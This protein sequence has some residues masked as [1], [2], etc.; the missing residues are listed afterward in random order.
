MGRW[1]VVLVLALALGAAFVYWEREPGPC[2]C[3][4]P[5]GPSERALAPPPVP[6]SDSDLLRQH[7]LASLAVFPGPGFPA[8]LPWGTLQQIGV[9]DGV[10]L[11]NL[12]HNH[13]LTFLEMCL[14]RYENEVHGYN[15]VMLKRERIGGKLYPP[16]G[17]EKVRASFREKPFSVLMVWLE[18]GRQAQKV[19]YVEGENNDKMLVRPAG[20][21]LSA[22][23]VTRDVNGAEAKEAGLYTVDQFG[24]YLA[25]K[26]SVVAMRAAQARGTLHLRYEGLVTLAEMGNRP[27][28][29]FERTPYEPPED[30]GINDLVLYI[31][32]ETWLQVGSTLRDA[33]GE[34]IGE[35][36]FRDIELNPSF[37]PKTFERSGF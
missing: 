5:P 30:N 10:P 18:N 8:G 31:D 33:Q 23:V 25:M 26:R 21:F 36:F 32:K 13:P 17:Y 3:L 27:C 12:L 6:L 29:K 7:V 35:Y 4:A 24:L 20:R 9:H 28:Y 16:T 2:L 34:L 11:E 1:S 19:L 15:L 22:L 14:E 37:A